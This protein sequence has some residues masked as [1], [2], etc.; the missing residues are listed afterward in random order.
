MKRKIMMKTL[1]DKCALVC[2]GSDGLGYGAATE[3]AKKGCKIILAGRSE[4]K[5]QEKLK[6][7]NELNGKENTSICVD[8]IDLEKLTSEVDHV[9][10]NNN[11][12]ILINN[13]GGPAPGKLSDATIDTLEIAFKLHILASHAITKKVLPSMLD[14][15]YGRI[16][17][18]VSTS[19]R[20]PIMGLGVS[21]TIRGAMASWSKTLS[22][23]LAEHGITVNCILPGT[24]KTDRLDSI[25]EA[26]QKNLGI[27]MEE[28][29]SIMLD[30]IPMQRFAEVEEISKA[31]AFSATPDASYITGVNLQ[32]DG[33]K[34]KSI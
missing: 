4:T 28:A 3:L 14:S 8:F 2:G 27:T 18:I 32:V 17:N 5:L 31:I 19:V 13:C 22:L 7:I 25:L 11:I 1:D 24:T 26:K 12:D 20:Q 9:L 10:V 16:V 29:K 23:E 34:I 21:N 30:E 15:G 6:L 33:G